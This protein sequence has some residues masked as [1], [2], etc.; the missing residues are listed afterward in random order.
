MK[1]EEALDSFEA[2][3]RRAALE[4]LWGKAQAGE[5]EL[6]AI[7]SQLNIHCHTFFSFNAYGYSPTHFAWKAR[8]EG[9]ALAGIVDFDVL[10]GLDELLAAGRLMNLKTTVGLETRVFVPE[11]ADWE[12]TSPGE[13]G[14]TY[15]M[16]MGFPTAELE[17]EAKTFQENLK[18][19][20]QERNRG[21]MGRVNPYLAPVELDYEKDILSLVPAGNATE[22][23][24]CVAYARKAR[25]VFGDNAALLKFWSE[26]LGP[27]VKAEDLPEGV[28]LLN[29]IRAK[30]MKRGGV[31]YVQPDSGSFPWMDKFNEFVLQAGG[32]PCLTWL[33]GTSEG[34]KHIEELLDIAESTGVEAINIIPDRNYGPKGGDEKYKN[35]CEIVAISK[36]RDL[37][38]VVGTEMNSFGQKFVDDFSSAELKPML[39]YALR[40]AYVFYAHAAMQRQCKLG[41]TSAWAKSHFPKRR[42]RNNYFEEVGKVLQPKKEERLGEFDSDTL[43][44][45]LLDEMANERYERC[46]ECER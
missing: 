46:E 17:G 42:D 21:L 14:I 30:T 39:A 15:H 22:R 31:G 19:T 7:G 35:L 4:E 43:P 9:L 37:V 6:G 18:Q 24:M 11:F 13:P 26:K 45:E 16:G 25:E 12:I 34:E 38:P 8:K 33:D 10:D 40:G 20:A 1:I 41:Y 44:D 27:G 5:I 2:S 3:E 36:R 28:P 32:I 23:H 29:L